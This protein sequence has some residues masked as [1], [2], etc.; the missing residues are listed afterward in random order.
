MRVKLPECDNDSRVLMCTND[1]EKVDSQWVTCIRI[2]LISDTNPRSD[3]F[4][5]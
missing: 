4:Q 3:D 5:A 1:N 2:H